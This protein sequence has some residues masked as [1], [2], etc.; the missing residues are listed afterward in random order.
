MVQSAYA[1]QRERSLSTQ[2]TL[3]T[4]NEARNLLEAKYPKGQS[5]F[6]RYYHSNLVCHNGYSFRQT[7][8]AN[9]ELPL[10]DAARLC[11][12]CLAAAEQSV[13]F[14]LPKVTELVAECVNEA[15]QPATFGN[16]RPNDW[17]MRDKLQGV[18]GMMARSIE[19]KLHQQ[20]DIAVPTGVGPCGICLAATK[21]A[22][23]HWPSQIIEWSIE[24]VHS[25]LHWSCPFP[26]HSGDD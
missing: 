15:L 3:I 21:A 1:L 14:L 16:R 19:T 4:A 24:V 18:T 10:H 26:H 6:W 12:Y 8:H 25:D 23:S 7:F 22:T 9:A 17:P 5:P 2:L 11:N 13:L 20:L